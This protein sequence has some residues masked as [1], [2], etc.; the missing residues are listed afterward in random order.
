MKLG[1]NNIYMNTSSTL[2]IYSFLLPSNFIVA[3]S[4]LKL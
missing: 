3:W 2:S 4:D 1:L